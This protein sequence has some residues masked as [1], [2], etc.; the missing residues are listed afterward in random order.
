MALTKLYTGL[1]V[2]AAVCLVCE[3]QGQEEEKTASTPLLYI[4]TLD[5]TFYAVDPATGRTQWE[6]QEEQVVSI[7][8]NFQ[9]NQKFFPD[10]LDGSLY[11]VN[12]GSIEKLAHTIPE[13]VNSSPMKTTNGL[14]YAGKKTDFWVALDPASG[15]KHASVTTQGVETCTAVT[16][17]SGAENKL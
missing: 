12:R 9:E 8:S 4:S 1:W 17:V 2:L 16:Q 15:N 14:L 5:G 7:P 13:M 3:C 6:M 10:P 11:V